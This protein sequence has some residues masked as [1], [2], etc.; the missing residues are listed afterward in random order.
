MIDPKK[1]N[2]RQFLAAL[3]AGG[4]VTAAGIWMPGEKTISIPK[5]RGGTPIMSPE[6]MGFESTWFLVDFTSRTV[7]KE[8]GDPT[9]ACKTELIC[10]G[11]AATFNS[12]LLDVVK[13]RPDMHIAKNDL[14]GYRM[15]ER[16]GTY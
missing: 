16:V 5:R 12:T 15:Y 1:L 8:T 6:E 11:D 4:V 7:Y 10:T 9:R 13:F 14:G 2:R 3:A